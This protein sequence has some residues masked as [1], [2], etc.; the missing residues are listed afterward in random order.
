M[1]R[2]KDIKRHF[3]KEVIERIGEHMKR[4]PT[5]LFSVEIQIRAK[6]MTSHSQVIAAIVERGKL[7]TLTLLP[8]M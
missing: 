6:G 4:W 8:W 5:F 7:G 2:I 3:T 1:T